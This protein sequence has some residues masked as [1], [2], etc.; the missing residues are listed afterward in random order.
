ME[1]KL[2]KARWP[3]LLEEEMQEIER[4]YNNNI[5]CDENCYQCKL[6]ELDK[7]DKN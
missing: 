2:F 4:H 7:L 6:D 5:K 3:N 1:K